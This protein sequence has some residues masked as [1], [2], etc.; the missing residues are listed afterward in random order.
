MTDPKPNVLIVDDEAYNLR[1]L[2]RL[3]KENN[4]NPIKA[5]D[6]AIAWDYLQKN[7]NGVDIILL[8]R[9]MPNMNGMQVMEKINAS[10]ALHHIPVIMQTA[11]SATNEVKE[12]IDAGVF[13]YLTKPFDEDILISIVHSA[14][15]TASCGKSLRQK[16]KKNELVIGSIT[17]AQFKIKTIEEAYN[18]SYFLA[19]YFPNPNK[20]VSGLYALI[21]N[22]IE[23]GNLQVDHNK[24]L[25]LLKTKGAWYK[26]IQHL[27][28]LPENKDKIVDIRYGLD[29]KAGEIKIYIKDQ[30][31]GFNWKSY[32]HIDIGRVFKPAGRGIAMAK[33]TS[34]DAIEFLG[35]GSEVLC[36]VKL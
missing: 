10:P 18:L 21:V 13:Y 24:R 26:E 7:P 30:G 22:A 4:Y 1:I 5:E 14:Y 11:A 25:E 20:V 27:S 16:I 28:S 23:H 34:F 6:G 35:N 12:G 15:E 3:L 2:E 9:M 32:M 33:K 29:E 36:T 31:R 8:D 19:K 17:M